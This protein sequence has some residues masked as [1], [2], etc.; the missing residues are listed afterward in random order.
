MLL[1]LL[2]MT[3]LL[4]QDSGARPPSL[5][6]G[7]QLAGEGRDRDALAMFQRVAAADPA[8]HAARIWIARLHERMGHPARAE[9]VYRSVLLEDRDNV[10]AMRG[11]GRTLLALDQTADAIAMLERADSLAP[12]NPEILAELGKAHAAAGHGALSV[13]YYR[14][15]VAAAPTLSHR[16]ASEQARRAYDHR[17]SLRGFQE[18]FSGPTPDTRASDLDLNLRLSSRL[19]GFARGQVQRKFRQTEYRAGGGAEWRWKPDT[20]LTGHAIVGP[21]N[22]VIPRGDYGGDITYAY[23][24]TGVTGGVRYFDFGRLH[25]VVLSPA[26]TW[27]PTERLSLGLQYALALT[28]LPGRTVTG[29]TGQLRGSYE[30]HPRVWADLGYTRGVDDF[31]NFSIERTG[32]VRANTGSAGVRIELPSLTSVKGMYEYQRRPGGPTM[33]RITLTLSQRF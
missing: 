29:H 18:Q 5:D 33:G 2:L 6:A 4:A 21:G 1:S 28:S 23:H 20:T 24:Q 22:D 17:V 9:A 3:A 31:E 19:R 10:E 15:A 30:V 26:G 8:N 12:T 11:V 14:R 27:W 13:S 25:T 16:M 32:D 7:I